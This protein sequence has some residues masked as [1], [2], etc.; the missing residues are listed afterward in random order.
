[1]ATDASASTSEPTTTVPT[2]SVAGPNALRTLSDTIRMTAWEEIQK[3]L[4]K[5]PVAQNLQGVTEP[6]GLSA[7]PARPT[8][9]MGEAQVDKC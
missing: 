8:G 3:P 5:A 1:M 2:S 4:P 9:S 6:P 7:D